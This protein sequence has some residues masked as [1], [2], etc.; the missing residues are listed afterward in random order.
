[1]SLISHLKT[2]HSEPTVLYRNKNVDNDNVSIIK[3]IKM[4]SHSLLFGVLNFFFEYS[5]ALCTLAA[6][7]CLKAADT[8][9]RLLEGKFVPSC[10]L[11]LFI[12]CLSWEIL[13]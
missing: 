10:E 6:I 5:I 2:K 3:R 11:Q 12:N 9:R 13:P 8:I 1:M 7:A 4:L